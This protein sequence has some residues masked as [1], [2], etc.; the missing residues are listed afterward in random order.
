MKKQSYGSCT[1]TQQKAT[2]PAFQPQMHTEVT[3][4]M[5]VIVHEK[6]VLNTLP[7][8]KYG[9]ATCILRWG[10]AGIFQF[11]CTEFPGEL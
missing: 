11:Q 4:V 1:R 2:D 10:G 7:W 6:R 8:V 5:N 3:L 9:A